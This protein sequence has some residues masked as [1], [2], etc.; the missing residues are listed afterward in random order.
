MTRVYRITMLGGLAVQVG[1]DTVR[2]F[3]TKKTASLLSLLAFH[4]GRSYSRAEL[5][6]LLWPGEEFDSSRNRLRICLNSLRRLLEPLGVAYG[7]VL[8]AD[9]TAVCLQPEC[10][11]TDVEE[12]KQG[13]QSS[14]GERVRRAL[15]LYRGPLLPDLDDDWVWAARA[16][17]SSLYVSALRRLSNAEVD[18]RRC[19][20]AL[21]LAYQALEEDPAAD[22]FQVLALE[23]GPSVPEVD[24]GKPAIV[25][26][27]HGLPTQYT[28]F[29][30]RE[31][32]VEELTTVLATARLVTLVGTGGVG[33]TRLALEIGSRVEELG[34]R[35]V[36][37][38]SFAEC[39]ER[40]QVIATLARHFKLR[41]EVDE[42]IW[43]GL[44]GVFSQC[45][46]MLILDN[47]EQITDFM[48]GMAAAL[49]Q[50][51]S[52]LS[53]LCTSRRP[54]QCRCE[55]VRVIDPLPVPSSEGVS[56]EERASNPSLQ[57]L[58]DRARSVR[59]DFAVTSRSAP[60]LVQLCHV[61][62]GLPLAIE[63]AACRVRNL[64]M[65]DLLARATARLDFLKG[66]HADR[67]VRHRSLSAALEWSYD[68]LGEEERR[69]FRELSV[70]RGGWTMALAAELIG[71]T[72]GPESC[73]RLCEDS[74]AYSREG[75]YRM[76]ET[77]REYAQA[78]ISADER[79]GVGRRHLAIF[80][81]LAREVASNLDGSSQKE[82]LDVLDSEIENIRAAFEFGESDGDSEEIVAGL[83]LDLTEYW[84]C[85]GPLSE[86]RAWFSKAIDSGWGDARLFLGASVLAEMQNDLTTAEQLA[87]R[88]LEQAGSSAVGAALLSCLGAIAKKRTEHASAACFWEEALETYRQLGNEQ[89]AGKTLL[90]LSTIPRASREFAKAT[91]L[92]EE[93]LSIF[94]RHGNRQ[95]TALALQNLGLL[96]CYRSEWTRS[97][98]LLERAAEIRRGLGDQNGLAFSLGAL[99]Q[100]ALDAGWHEEAWRYYSDCLD[101]CLQ[102]EYRTGW[103]HCL[104]DLSNAWCRI[105]PHEVGARLLGAS[106][107]HHRQ[108]GIRLE[109][110]EEEL[111]Q[112]SMTCLE[113][114]LGIETRDALLLSGSTL[115][116]PTAVLMVRDQL[117]SLRNAFRE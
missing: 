93:A 81:A 30:G 8:Q 108:I 69:A 43:Q 73:E 29:I 58:V 99:G 107:A 49:T 12:F 27:G 28:K 19:D 38:V 97:K 104:W 96:A 70:F 64:S 77:V 61:L 85:R 26:R 114:H 23:A 2:R 5:C 116:L 66:R 55:L 63:L 95:Q 110:G 88:G 106:R 11:S 56:E 68:L 13:I 82:W 86:G 51:Y 48:G 67:D 100:T 105:G 102:S 44:D 16:H 17:L 53:I 65:Q 45:Q 32:E 103:E 76:L 25:E 4:S 89:A 20:E 22:G 21:Q 115:D 9:R 62:E 31:A 18:G 35:K 75:R 109:P 39:R 3:R 34:E 6:E 40:S 57:L 60:A 42:D 83:C 91:Q 79:L 47:L 7:S 98:L 117:V 41:V 111:L 10:C 94:E 80:A 113:S 101:L 33:K 74:L 54:L 14:E 46:G 71:D 1:A 59:P 72:L 50:R 78:Q 112:E 52:G 87:A 24:R 37:F 90:S 15:E 36:W 92:C 84:K